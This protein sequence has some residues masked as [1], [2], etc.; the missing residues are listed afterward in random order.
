[1]RPPLRIGADYDFRNTAASGMDMPNVAPPGE[2]GGG[3]TP[4][5]PDSQQTAAVQESSFFLAYTK[6]RY[7]GLYFLIS[8]LI[9]LGMNLII[10]RPWNVVALNL[11]QILCLYVFT[12]EII[13]MYR[14]IRHGN[15]EVL[16][17]WGFHA[18]FVVAIAAYVATFPFLGW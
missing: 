2:G 17:R 10:Q 5:N 12:G 7:I 1:M 15:R 8:P 4:A 14:L 18:C 13:L 16:Q 9:A 6:W 11:V 3:M